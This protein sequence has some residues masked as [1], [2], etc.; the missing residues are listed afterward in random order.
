MKQAYF[1]V[2]YLSI[3]AFLGYN[4]WSS[5]QAFKAFVPMN[6][7]LNAD[8]EVMEN[9]A[10]FTCKAIEKGYKQYPN[11]FNLVIFSKSQN[12]VKAVNEVIDFIEK[13]KL[14]LN[15]DTINPFNYKPNSPN[16]SFFADYKVA[17]I[18]SKLLKFSNVM[19]QFIS[20]PKARQIIESQ[21]ITPKII[22][23]E[24]YWQM[25]KHQSLNG[26]LMQLSFL[27]NQ[28]KLDEITLLN[29]LYFE[30]IEKAGESIEFDSYKTAIAP[31]KATLIEGETF[32]ADIYIAKFAS[33][34]INA[35]I[36]VN[37]QILETKEGVAHFKSKKQ[38][39]GIKKIT[40]ETVIK[41]PWTGTTITSQGYFE[42]EVL[43]KC[44]RDCQ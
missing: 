28:I 12:A 8:S 22:H 30:Q 14:E 31:K 15:L 35:T 25:M 6:V 34:P 23:D 2:I 5:V 19:I 39:I 18:Q 1:H 13:N 32:E 29:Y 16:N 41:N 43:P 10:V 33:N 40:A 27:E 37:G 44:H 4:Y 11:V 21:L 38:S 24:Y 7:Q 36:K 26:V 17:E 9:A 42:Y 3:I 20:D